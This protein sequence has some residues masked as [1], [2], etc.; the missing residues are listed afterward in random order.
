[1]P[2]YDGGGS[3]L[4]HDLGCAGVFFIRNNLFPKLEVFGPEI[5]GRPEAE[6]ILREGGIGGEHGDG[7]GRKMVRLEEKLV[8]EIAHEIANGE[9]EP[10]LEVS[11]E[12]D[13]LTG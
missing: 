3:A 8:E 7:V 4:G 12:D 9:P 10:A 11:N 2:R 1:M 5:D 6:I 13:I